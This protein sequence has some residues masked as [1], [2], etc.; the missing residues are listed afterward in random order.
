MDLK[1][2]LAKR[3]H[4]GEAGMARAQSSLRVA[5][6]QHTEQAR[7]REQE[8]EGVIK[9]MERLAEDNHLAALVW[10]VVIGNGGHRE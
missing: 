2:W 1:R 6:A 3:K 9:R 5:K 8:Q 7:K 10:D 4:S